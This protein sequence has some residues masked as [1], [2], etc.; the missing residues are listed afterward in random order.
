MDNTQYKF[1]RSTSNA[2][3]LDLTK[4]FNNL[5]FER[6]PLQIKAPYYI[7]LA[8]LEDF[9]RL[10][11]AFERTSMLTFSFKFNGDDIFAVQMD[12]LDNKPVIYYV[13]CNKM[14]DYLA[15]R[16]SNG[17]E[18]VLVVDSIQNPTFVYSPIITIIK[19]PSILSKSSSP[20][21]S[22][23]YVPIGVKDLS[24]LARMA[25]FKMIY[26]E[27]PLPLFIFKNTKSPDK[28]IIGTPLS[29]NESDNLSYFY[30]VK[31]NEPNYCFLK[32]SAQRSE[33]PVI[34]KN[35][36]EHGY[37]YLKLIKL[38]GL[39]PLVKIYD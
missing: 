5:R 35:I 32:Y 6:Y 33:A 31:N 22:P 19:A 16:N 12:F 38:V 9:G 14:G 28:C 18:E 15:Y 8:S 34:S 10:V 26:D 13:R 23:K 7:E 17:Y 27:P 30:Y 25:S 2:K 37:I 36:D 39:H 11:C 1:G 29:L 20:P 24:S 21:K 4:P 3:K